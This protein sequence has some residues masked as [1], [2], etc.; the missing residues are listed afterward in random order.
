MLGLML[1]ASLALIY[2][3]GLIQLGMWLG[4]VKGEPVSLTTL[5]TMGAIPFIAGDITKVVA[6]AFIA[7][8]ILP[9]EDT[10]R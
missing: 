2:V 5:I 4:M 1:V 10:Q 9:R 6:A 8:S 3:P 7:R